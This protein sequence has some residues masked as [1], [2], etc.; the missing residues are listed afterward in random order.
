MP[1]NQNY[2]WDEIFDV[3]VVGSG[4]GIDAGKAARDIGPVAAPPPGARDRRE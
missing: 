3:A 4:G 2:Q 1:G